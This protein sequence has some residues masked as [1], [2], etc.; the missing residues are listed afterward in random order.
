MAR[1]DRIINLISQTVMVRLDR[2]I[3]HRSTNTATTRRPRRRPYR[4]PPL[5]ARHRRYG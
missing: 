3:N 1:L 2:T 4:L 5:V